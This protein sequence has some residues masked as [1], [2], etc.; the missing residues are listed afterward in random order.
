MSPADLAS[1]H[2]TGLALTGM[3]LLGGVVTIAIWPASRPVWTIA[4]AIMAPLFAIM[5]LLRGRKSRALDNAAFL[6]VLAVVLAAAYANNQQLAMGAS[7]FE[8]FLAC[9]LA[10]VAIALL[11]PADLW[12][13]LV[14]MASAALLP[15]V[16]FFGWP[17]EVQRRAPQPEPW[18]VLVYLVTAAVVLFYRRHQWAVHDQLTRLQAQAAANERYMRKFL[19]VRDMANS[20]LQAIEHT[21]EFLRV[22]FPDA[23]P[24]IDR[25]SRSLDRL[26]QLSAALDRFQPKDWVTKDTAFDPLE[27]LLEPERG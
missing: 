18:T 21:T 13:A 8:P 3:A 1:G 2:R 5:V 10:L 24:Q 23:A 15:I 25:M 14:G 17:V 9:K 7:R 27:V 26:R 6:I 20:P 16:A 12:V 11:A 4:V 22:R 19:A